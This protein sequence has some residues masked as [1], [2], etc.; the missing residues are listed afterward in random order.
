MLSSQVYSLFTKEVLTNMPVKESETNSSLSDIHITEKKIIEKIKSLKQNS[1]PGPDEIGTKLLKTASREIA[2]PLCYI[3]NESLRTGL[4]PADWRKA[5]VTPIFKKGPKGD[6]GNYRP[7]S[8]TSIPCRMMESII[9]DDLMPYLTENKLLRE[10]QHGFLTG[11]SCTTNLIKFTDK[12]TR[13]LDEGKCADVFYLNFAKAFDKVPHGRLLTKMKSKGIN[14]KVHEWIKSWLSGRTQAVRVNTS[15]SEPS[16]VESGVP[17]G[18][19][20]GPPL[21]D[22]F[23]DD[24]DTCTS[25]ISL[26]LK[27]ADDTKGFQVIQGPGDRDKLQNALDNLVQWANTY[28]NEVQHTKMQ[29]NA[30]RKK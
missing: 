30:R 8:L 1:A 7:V 20:L 16:E 14:G 29:N 4:V 12:I 3:F 18:S 15:K 22:I 6:P 9:K 10:S 17:Q 25:E 21:F 11:R 27:F 19:V 24:I 13:I 23:I 5:T 2:K 28:G 26:L